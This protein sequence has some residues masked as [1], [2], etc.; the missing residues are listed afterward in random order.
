MNILIDNREHSLFMKTLDTYSIKYKTSTLLYGD[1]WFVNDK[2]E[3]IMILER[4]TRDDFESSIKDGRSHNQAFKLKEIDG[5]S[6]VIVGYLIEMSITSYEDK[7]IQAMINKQVRDG[8]HIFHTKDMK[9]SAIYIKKIKKCIEK[10]GTYKQQLKEETFTSTIKLPKCSNKNDPGCI[11]ICML[12][13][14]PGV[15][16]AI[17]RAIYSKYPSMLYLFTHMVEHGEESLVGLQINA[18]RKIGKVISKRI[19]ST[20][21]HKSE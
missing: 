1:I 13:C 16:D 11:Y 10:H 9:E 2:N 20:L 7:V 18:K 4:K 15:S 17:A 8:F 14:I 21:F 6:N 5:N 3:P 19:Y 12:R